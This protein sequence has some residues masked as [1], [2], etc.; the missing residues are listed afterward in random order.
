VKKR[1]LYKDEI[2]KSLIIYTI[3]FMVISILLIYTFLSVYTLSTIKKRNNDFNN[4]VN[5]FLNQEIEKYADELYDLEEG[6]EFRD[7][8]NGKDNE[9]EIYELL[10]AFNNA[11]DIKSI[12][13][14]VD[15]QGKTVLTNNYV[16]SPYNSYTLFLSGLF[17]QLKENP[18]EI[19]YMNNKIQ[20]DLTKRTI[21][22]IGKTIRVDGEIKGYLIFDLLEADLKKLAY[23][24]D[25]DIFIITDKYNNEIV[26]TNGL[27]L[28][29]IGKFTLA[30]KADNP[31]EF[32][33][34]KYYF[35][36]SELLDGQMF[37]YTLSELDLIGSLFNISIIF[38][39]IMIPVISIII[40]SV[41]DRVS[42]TKTRS[43]E[44]LIDSINQ[45][46]KGNLEAYVSIKSNDEFERIGDQFNRML[47]EL[48]RL[49]ERNNELIDR[50]RISQIKQLE[51][52]FNP[53][54]IF[55][56]LQT[57][58]YMIHLEQDKAS[59]FIV[60]FS[61]ILR[62]SIDYEKTTVT[63][64]QDLDYLRSYLMIQKYRFNKRLTYEFNIDENA[65]QCIVPK[66]IM[67]PIVENCINHG[68][69]DKESLHI[70]LEILKIGNELKMV[71]QDN[72]DG[73]PAFK[74]K[75][76]RE[77]LDDDS[78][79]I[80]LSNVHRRLKLSY[81]GRYGLS[82]DSTKGE[83]TIVT[84]KMPCQKW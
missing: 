19:V 78:N 27:V 55:N 51:S 3:S 42:T 60:N 62:Y 21:Y 6:P 70:S 1:H 40:C 37:I 4:T 5:R 81:G 2:R 69:K 64:E 7:Y 53:H 44:L 18:D 50:N 75:K 36:K 47:L 30:K 80:G 43:I 58:K 12:F 71:I 83:G 39:V 11:S 49:I 66:L 13:Y 52:Q 33:G 31:L 72:G 76:L 35:C 26:T 79:N 15:T 54:F 10:Y 20:I 25:A 17:K 29:N 28:D 23:S 34:N 84:I 65:K 46:E 22:S 77:G 38:L 16:E 9:S 41:A 45:V 73:I 48:N 61:N 57:L 14:I 67:Q 59:D 8:F 56:T 32:M 68:Y 82:I 63:L 24:S 74:L